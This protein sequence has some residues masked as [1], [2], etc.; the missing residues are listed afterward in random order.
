MSTTKP[1][2]ADMKP[3]KTELEAG[4]TYYWCKCG[5]STNQPFCDGSHQGTGITPVQF[6]LTEKTKV[7]LCGCKQ[8]ADKPF[9]DGSH[10]QL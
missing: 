5:L 2:I 10:K 9:C 1:I 4:K 3:A 6:A 8:T 7:W